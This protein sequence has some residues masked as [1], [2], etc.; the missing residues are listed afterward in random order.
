MPAGQWV[1]FENNDPHKCEKPPLR[2][3][4]DQPLREKRPI[5]DDVGFEEIEVPTTNHGRQDGLTKDLPRMPNVD[6]SVSKGQP[7]ASPDHYQNQA[8]EPARGVLEGLWTWVSPLIWITVVLGV[9]RLLVSIG[10]MHP[11]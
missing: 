8:V 4:R 3:A 7:K 10:T 11:R 9:L 1:P 6:S 2:T 5:V